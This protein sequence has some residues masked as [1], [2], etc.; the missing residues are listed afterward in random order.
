[1]MTRDPKRKFRTAIS[2]RTQAVGRLNVNL[3]ITSIVNKCNTWYQV[4]GKNYHLRG[5]YKNVLLKNKEIQQ[6]GKMM[7]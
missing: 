6:Q 2:N 4:P 3:F 7:E 1:M 5:K